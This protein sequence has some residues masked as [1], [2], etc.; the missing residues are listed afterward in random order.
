M[1]VSD[2][3]EFSIKAGSANVLLTDMAITKGS[4]GGYSRTEVSL[5]KTV[6]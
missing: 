1:P 2:F 4:S 6:T 5:T 3:T